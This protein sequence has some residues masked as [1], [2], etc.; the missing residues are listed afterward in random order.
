[1]DNMNLN[2]VPDLKT[3]RYPK[4]I[5]VAVS[6]E[7]FDYLERLKNKKNKQSNELLRML[8]ENF[9]KANPL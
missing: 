1:M 5:S 7:M 3:K 9:M 8:L 6:L 4:N 2:D